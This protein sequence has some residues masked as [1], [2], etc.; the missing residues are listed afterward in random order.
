MWS[1]IYCE[2]MTPELSSYTR[3][4]VGQLAT[5]VD[6]LV[7]FNC[8]SMQEKGFCPGYPFLSCSLD[9]YRHSLI[10]TRFP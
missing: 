6:Q 10:S 8:R 2:K 4:F 5:G 1:A 9:R 3:L 7:D